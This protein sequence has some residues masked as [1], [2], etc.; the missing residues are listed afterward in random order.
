MPRALDYRSAAR[1]VV[2]DIESLSEIARTLERTL[3]DFGCAGSEVAKSI[4]LGLTASMT[5]AGN[6][7][8]QCHTLVEELERRATL[9]EEYTDAMNTYHWSTLPNWLEAQASFE[10]SS[11]RGGSAPTAGPRPSP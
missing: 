6:A 2:L 11:S 9:C 10:A 3:G 8:E 4:E 7:A 1:T 5:N